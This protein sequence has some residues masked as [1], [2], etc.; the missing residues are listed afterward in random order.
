MDRQDRVQGRG[1]RDHVMRRL[2]EESR[3]AAL[4]E[5]AFMMP[6]LAAMAV[7][8]YSFG[9]VCL[10]KDKLAEAVRDGAR[11]AAG[12]PRDF[13]TTTCSLGGSSYNVPCSVA[14]AMTT[15]V[16]DLNSFN[17]TACTVN[18]S[19]AA[20][21]NYAW[22]YSSSSASCNGNPIFEI[23]RNVQVASGGVTLFLTRVTVNYPVTW[24]FASVLKL[25][26][27]S[28]NLPSSFWITAQAVMPNLS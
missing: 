11:I 19:A 5:F 26:A 3:G 20:L 1:R 7:G 12:Q 17:M 23:E 27:P 8:I 25:L 24:S 13:S 16:N 22:S 6:L 10:M 4:L 28:S 9:S 14:A 15:M 18:P 2:V 21:G